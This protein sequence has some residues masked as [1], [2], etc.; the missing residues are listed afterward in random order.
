[1]ILPSEIPD[2]K[3]NNSIFFLKISLIYQFPIAIPKML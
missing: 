3:M 1:M 2:R